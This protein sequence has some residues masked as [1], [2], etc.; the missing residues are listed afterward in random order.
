MISRLKMKISLPN[1]LLKDIKLEYPQVFT[2]TKKAATLASQ[3]FNLPVISDDETGFICL[4]FAKYY[5]ENNK[6]NKKIKAYVIC[7]TGIGTSGIISTKIKNSI[8]E[9]EIVGLASNYDVESIIKNEPEIELLISTVPI[10]YHGKIP[11]ELVSAFFTKKDEQ[12][13]RNVVR[14]IINERNFA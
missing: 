3:K 8:P 4:Y 5:E 12:K 13:V 14:N 6:S 7:T 11:V 1:A 10:N 2:A 9:I